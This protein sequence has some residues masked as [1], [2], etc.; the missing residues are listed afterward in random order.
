MTSVFG[1]GHDVPGLLWRVPVVLQA[2][3][4]LPL[5]PVGWGESVRVEGPRGAQHGHSRSGGP[6]LLDERG[7]GMDGQ[8]T[9]G[10]KE[11]SSADRIVDRLLVGNGENSRSFKTA[12]GTRCL[13]GP[14][15]VGSWRTSNT[16]YGG[17]SRVRW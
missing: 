3:R 16:T 10:E 8:K 7:K 17:V 13:A 11:K 4:V 12:S 1:A 9:S 5:L 6:F 15:T 2:V 14:S